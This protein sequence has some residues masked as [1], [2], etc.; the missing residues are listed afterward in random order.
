MKNEKLESFA[1]KG[2][3]IELQDGYS[4]ISVTANKIVRAELVKKEA[5]KIRELLDSGNK[6]SISPE[7]ESFDQYLVRT[8]SLSDYCDRTPKSNE[9]KTQL[10]AKKEYPLNVIIK[11]VKSMI[12]RK[13]NFTPDGLKAMLDQTSK[14]SPDDQ[15]RNVL[16]NILL[17]IE[18]NYGTSAVEQVSIILEK[19]MLDL[20][21]NAANSYTQSEKQLLRN[22]FRLIGNYHENSATY[23]YIDE[24]S[25]AEFFT[26]I[27]DH[28][29]C[30]NE[31]SNE[32]REAYMGE[33]AQSILE[34]F[35]K[36]AKKGFYQVC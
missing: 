33:G 10:D 28:V 34:R 20:N 25:G 15:P 27:S 22:I 16:N 19:S 2:F 6:I 24:F 11:A 3:D 35:K 7:T 5:T 23:S 17:L 18:K 1:I 14:C 12:D 8:M 21:I 32:W 31:R 13:L 36:Q 30:Y 29:V 9:N 26:C 4:V